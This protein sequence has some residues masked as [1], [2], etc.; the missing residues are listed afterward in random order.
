MFNSVLSRISLCSLMILCTI[1]T[2]YCQELK[3][4]QNAQTSVSGDLKEQELRAQFGTTRFRPPQSV[5]SLFLSPEEKYVVSVSR[6]LSIWDTESGLE[7]R[8]LE[9]SKI[10]VRN[11]NSS[12]GNRPLVFSQETG[13]LIGLGRPGFIVEYDPSNDEYH[14]F[15]VTN[16]LLP[17]SQS[18]SPLSIDLSKDDQFLAVGSA[19][20]IVVLDAEKEE[21][22]SV[23][24]DF[25]APIEDKED[26]LAFSGHYSMLRISPKNDVIAYTLSGKPKTLVIAEL[27]TGEAI[28]SISLTDKLVRMDFSPDGTA[29]AVTERDSSVRSYQVEDGVMNWEFKAPLN[30][31]YENYT[32]DIAFEPNGKRIAVCATDNQIYIL[33]SASGNV[34]GKLNGHEWYPWALAFSSKRNL[35][36]SSGWD[37][38]IRRWDMEHYRE[39]PLPGA[40]YASSIISFSP[41][42]NRVA[43]VY[44]KGR[45]A[46]LSENDLREQASITAKE[47]ELS[48]I[49]FSAD[50]RWLAYGGATKTEVH[51]RVVDLQANRETHHWQWPL[52]KDPHSSV[53]SLKF[54]NDS[55]TLAAAVFRQ[56]SAYLM[57]L[58]KPGEKQALK[59]S[60][61]YGLDFALDGKKLVTAGWDSKV[62]SWDAIDGKLLAD[63]DVA[64]PNQNPNQRVDQRMYTI[65]AYPFGNLVATADM[66]S[67]VRVWQLGDSIELVNSIPGNSFTFGAMDLSSD[68]IW[69]VT[70][71][72]G[73]NVK[74][75]NA[76]SGALALDAGKHDHYIH[77]V[78][79][80]KDVR[81]V[82]S[83]SSD[84]ICK[85]WNTKRIGIKE[86]ATIDEW[87]VELADESEEIGFQA[88]VRAVEH[89]EKALKQVQLEIRKLDSEKPAVLRIAPRL[90]SLLGMLKTPESEAYLRELV[91]RD[92]NDPFYVLAKPMLRTPE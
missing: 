54:S 13:R 72:S 51:V 21:I 43:V 39:L 38:K 83:G 85:I 6:N 78:N 55:N 7:I 11:T 86:S 76:L 12:Y 40:E 9:P 17:R 74:I 89:P 18:D 64:L 22:W 77:T 3:L 19:K 75:W 61:I 29:I 68:G 44:E 14:E 45:I 49:A 71:S 20:G 10:P 4:K 66:D 26:R 36:Y 2:A 81:Q 65:V 28:C 90:V 82:C 34:I 73:G 35:L 24:N 56:S 8:K 88:M 5:N 25:V 30:N 87:L 52:G 1:S 50:D 60:Q 69:L 48:A 32:S 79:F 47:I 63:L 53:E 58:D 59:H 37:G 67:T 42:G 15:P 57:T 62:R 80:G 91:K 84:G 70:G 16:D 31:P 41:S 33:D 46:V 23:E 92:A 27:T